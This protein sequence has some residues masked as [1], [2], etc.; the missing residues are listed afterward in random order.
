MSLAGESGLVHYEEKGTVK[1][2]YLL[3]PSVTRADDGKYRS[4]QTLVFQ[5]NCGRRPQVNLRTSW[6][7]EQYIAILRVAQRYQNHRSSQV[8]KKN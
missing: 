5:T 2:S 3:L 7:R 6:G 8:H 1:N 4:D